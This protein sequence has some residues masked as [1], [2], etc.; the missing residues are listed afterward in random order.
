M[1]LEHRCIYK[2]YRT[3]ASPIEHRCIYKEYR[4]GASPHTLAA[5]GFAPLELK[6][7]WPAPVGVE[8][9]C[10][11][12]AH[13]LLAVRPLRGCHLHRGNPQGFSPICRRNATTQTEMGL[14]Y[15]IYS[16]KQASVAIDHYKARHTLKCHSQPQ[17]CDLR[18]LRCFVGSSR[19]F[20]LF[21]LP[22][23]WHTISC[24]RKCPDNL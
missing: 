1:L 22:S 10:P 6:D 7:P 2:E 18:S 4:T 15:N 9:V 23:K 12:N 8:E 16:T 14:I 21:G 24:A 11:S 20:F 13:R 5:G 3:G 17:R 19:S